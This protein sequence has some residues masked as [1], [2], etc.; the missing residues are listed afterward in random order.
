MP[1]FI[2]GTANLHKNHVEKLAYNLC[3]PDAVEPIPFD[4]NCSLVCYLKQPYVSGVVTFYTYREDCNNDLI[5]TRLYAPNFF[6]ILIGCPADYNEDSVNNNTWVGTANHT[7]SQGVDNVGDPAGYRLKFDAVMTANTSG[8]LG[9]SVSI[10]RLMPGSLQYVGCNS[11]SF[12]LTEVASTDDGDYGRNYRSPL[13]ATSFND[14]ECGGE[15]K[16]VM[17]EIALIS[18]H[19]G[20]SLSYENAAPK[21]NLRSKRGG[22]IRE[23]SCLVVLASPKDKV[24]WTP[25]V[26]QLGVNSDNC[27][28]ADSCGCYYYDGIQMYPNR[29][30]PAELLNVGCP[31]ESFTDRKQRIQFGYV[32]VSGLGSYEIILKTIGVSAICVAVR[33]VG[34]TAGPWVIGSIKFLKY[35][36]PLVMQA[37]FTGLLAGDPVFQ[38]Y[39]LEFP[40]ATV[41]ECQVNPIQDAAYFENPEEFKTKLIEDKKGNTETEASMNKAREIVKR[42]Y[43]VKKNPCVSL[44][45][46]LEQVASCGCGGSVLH[47]CKKHGTCRQSGNDEKVQL[48]WKCPDYAGKQ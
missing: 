41:E 25:Q 18:Y 40:T 47:E 37:D 20:C 21:C 28:E 8:T 2:S 42:I 19:F 35:T 48:C 24:S 12:E 10:S 36:S 30:F 15:V 43:Q 9:L 13:V 46:A 33:V 23:Y 38:F 16:Y 39:G 17:A 7:T 31:D 29:E 14:N 1:Y 6:M 44:G 11:T 45:M 22:F 3:D 34:I 4:I 27:G 32:G 26:A 5:G